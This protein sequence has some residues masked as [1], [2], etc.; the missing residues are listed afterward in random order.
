LDALLALHFMEL[1][2]LRRLGHFGE[3]LC[4]QLVMHFVEDGFAFSWVRLLEGVFFNLAAK[5][6]IVGCHRNFDATL[7]SDTRVGFS[8][9]PAHINLRQ[10]YLQVIL[11]ALLRIKLYESVRT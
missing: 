8:N 1:E 10:A 6:T 7:A 4:N 3:D 11:S 5:L 9:K 2:A